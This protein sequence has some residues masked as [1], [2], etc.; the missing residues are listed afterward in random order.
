MDAP[1]ERSETNSTTTR[2]H[3]ALTGKSSCTGEQLRCFAFIRK[4]LTRPAPGA[5]PRV[6]PIL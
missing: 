3:A 5:A 1:V 4:E 2:R 6:T